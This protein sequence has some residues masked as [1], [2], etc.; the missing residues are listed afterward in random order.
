[1]EILRAEIQKNRG[2]AQPEK[3]RVV[4]EIGLRIQQGLLRVCNGID[5][6]HVDPIHGA[7]IDLRLDGCILVKEG[8]FQ[9][10]LP[11]V[12]E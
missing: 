10:C 6:S 2:V 1:M 12:V 8:K 7:A 3:T 4:E 5:G 11:G 9:A